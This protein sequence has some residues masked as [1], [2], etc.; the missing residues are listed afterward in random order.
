MYFCFE[1]RSLWKTVAAALQC[2]RL[3]RKRRVL[4]DDFR[5]PHIDLLFGTDSWVEHIDN[6][7]KC[8]LFGLLLDFKFE[9]GFI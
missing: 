8:V 4:D 7:I 9:T 1:G 3:A 2:K 5:R 6:G